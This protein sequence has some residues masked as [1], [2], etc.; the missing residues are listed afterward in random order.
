M[1]KTL[2]FFIALVIGASLAAP[3]AQAQNADFRLFNQTGFEINQ[4]YISPSNSRNWGRDRLG[5]ETLPNGRYWTLRFPNAQS[6]CVQDMKVVFSDGDE[7]VYERLNL[8][9]F[10]RLTLRYNRSNRRV[11]YETE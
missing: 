6:Q 2:A 3:A 5:D 1:V 7:I 8:C 10:S 9:T 11:W 4:I